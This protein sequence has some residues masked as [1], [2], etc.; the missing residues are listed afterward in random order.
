[1]NADNAPAPTIKLTEEQGNNII[2]AVVSG[3]Y[4]EYAM[5]CAVAGVRPLGSREDFE[6]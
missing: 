6:A 3:S 2:F 4:E 5:R 1:M